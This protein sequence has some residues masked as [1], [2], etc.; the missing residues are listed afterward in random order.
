MWSERIKKEGKRRKA[1]E[2][3][4]LPLAILAVSVSS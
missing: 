3:E 1:R 2:G 4:F